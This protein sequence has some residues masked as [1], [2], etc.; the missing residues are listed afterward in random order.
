MGTDVSRIVARSMTMDFTMFHVQASWAVFVPNV[1]GG[2]FRHGL[3]QLMRY[4]I[5]ETLFTRRSPG[6]LAQEG[7]TFPFQLRPERLRL[8]PLLWVD[9]LVD[10]SWAEEKSLS[11]KVR[12]L[13]YDPTAASLHIESR[14]FAV[15]R[16]LLNDA[17]NPVTVTV[18]K[19]N[20]PLG[21]GSPCLSWSSCS[22]TCWCFSQHS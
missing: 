15:F 20:R 10:G 5:S 14:G 6:R 4:H 11:T 22:F 1:A 17:E 8:W 21:K 7:S 12:W 3:I 13:R 9:S 2:P 18:V 16:V 19:A